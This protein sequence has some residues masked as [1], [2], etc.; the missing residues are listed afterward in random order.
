MGC[1]LSPKY[2]NTICLP[3]QIS[4]GYEGESN[5]SRT[6][7]VVNEEDFDSAPELA[8]LELIHKILKRTKRNRSQPRRSATISH[9]SEGNSTSGSI[10]LNV[11]IAI[12][13]IGSP[14]STRELGPKPGEFL[15]I[16]EITSS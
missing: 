4:L 5:L 15:E 6:V 10:Y 3:R 8:E 16:E 13:P 14:D 7:S 2:E 1:S 12:D 11:Q 9:I